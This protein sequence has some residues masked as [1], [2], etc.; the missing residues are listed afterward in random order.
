MINFLHRHQRP[1]L[2]THIRPDGDGLGSQ[3]ALAD[4][5]RLLDK[6]PRVMIASPLP[7]RYRFLDPERIV[8]EDFRQPKTPLDD[9]DC[10][11]ILDTGTWSQLG[12]FGTFLKQSPLPRVV[13]DHHRTQ[14]DLGGASFVD[15]S[16]EATGRLTYE[17]I[18]ELGAPLTPTSANALFLALAHDT[19]WFRHSNTSPATFAL[20]ES[21]TSAG[22]NPTRLYQNLF[23]TSSLARL[24][25][26]SKALDRLQLHANGRIAFTEIYLTD[27]SQTGAVPADTEDLI[28]YPR[29]VVGV[30]I[31][32]LFIQQP[33]GSTKVSFR[34]R[35][36]DVSRI[37]EMLG[38]GGHQLAAGARVNDTLQNT[39]L[40]V[41]QELEKN[42][43]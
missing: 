32:I 14:D 16:A 35:G 1:L 20:A 15:I 21:L 10:I 7:P 40:R 24:R 8:I 5:L 27:Y 41:L 26:I 9:R 6:Q 3:L 34:S 36:L 31:A 42:L 39:K 38:G 33:D 30:E 4:A 23:E 18:N 37:A 29:S 2:M 17:I 25:L 19:G 12:D 43:I 11:V 13:I 28:E 22:A